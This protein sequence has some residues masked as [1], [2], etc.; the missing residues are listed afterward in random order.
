[1]NKEV[2]PSPRVSIG[3]PVYNGERHIAR[4]I[5]SVRQQGLTDFEVLLCDNGSTDG[6]RAVCEA[7]IEGDRRFRYLG[8]DVNR[9]PS[10]N[11][12]R[13]LD[14]ATGTYFMWLAS[15]DYIDPGYV[16]AC[17]NE[18]EA[19]ADVALASGRA[20]YYADGHHAPPSPTVSAVQDSRFLRIQS[21]AWN[22][23]ANG[24]F[25][26]V[27]RR[28]LV[29]H[30]KLAPMLG[31]DWLWMLEVAAVGKIVACPQV[32]IHRHDSWATTTP[33]AYYRKISAVLGAGRIASAFP[34]TAIAFGMGT[35]IAWRSSAFAAMGAPKRAA[36]A[37]LV[38]G[39]LWFRLTALMLRGVLSKLRA[40]RRGPRAH[41][42]ERK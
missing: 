14:T 18:L 4:A 23:A 17:I 40:R 19:D 12:Q 27:Y 5:E 25:Y 26:G 16:G 32:A 36:L 8:S 11:F 9:G 1:M 35:A 2:R 28:R 10:W 31:G 37:L 20:V 7:C 22:V 39:T 29:A 30:L 33:G 41:G 38:A 21:Y 24:A 6:T 3:I 15:D 34:R 13:C 42:V